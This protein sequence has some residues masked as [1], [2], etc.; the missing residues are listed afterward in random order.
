M[1]EEV[2]KEIIL[3]MFCSSA[4]KIMITDLFLNGFAFVSLKPHT[5]VLYS[6]KLVGGGEV[7]GDR[8]SPTNLGIN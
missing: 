4:L 8:W 1:I 3:E 7:G 2:I 6:Q 5:I